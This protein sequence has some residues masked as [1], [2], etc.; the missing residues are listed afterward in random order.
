M[1]PPHSARLAVL[2]ACSVSLAAEEQAPVLKDSEPAAPVAAS[3]APR[4]RL[5]SPVV[6]RQLTESAP[7]YA[8]PA[9]T[10]AKPAP[11]P[12]PR[13]TE[14]PRNKIIRLPDYVVSEPRIHLPKERDVLTD[15]GKLDLAFKRHP[16]LKLGFG[17]FNNIFWAN[18]MI[19]EE[20]AA[21]RRK[22]MNDLLSFIPPDKRPPP[23]SIETP[24]SIPRPFSGPWRGLVV[25]WEKK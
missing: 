9:P 21:E 16:G 15:K 24:F 3:T 11:P 2:L 5:I 12:E 8:P 14:R 10:E 6:A 7:K 1:R 17:P 22:E 25:P 23:I 18:A 13:E 20:I 4:P 19:E